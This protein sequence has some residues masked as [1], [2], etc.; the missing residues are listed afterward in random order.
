MI[1]VKDEVLVVR[2]GYDYSIVTVMTNR[3]QNSP[4]LGPYT[5]GDTNFIAGD[6]V[7][8]VLGCTTQIVQEYGEMSSW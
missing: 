4:D 8:D 1:L 7:M 6:T 2:K 5:I 3:G